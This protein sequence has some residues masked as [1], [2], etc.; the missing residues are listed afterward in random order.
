MD[1]EG[2]VVC[3]YANDETVRFEEH[4][5]AKVFRGKCPTGWAPEYPVDYEQLSSG[6][7]RYTYTNG[8]TIVRK[9]RRDLA[10]YWL[11]DETEWWRLGD[12]SE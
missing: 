12:P 4:Q 2:K 9:N 11:P 5:L 10:D 1:A 3:F 6:D 8:D 7:I